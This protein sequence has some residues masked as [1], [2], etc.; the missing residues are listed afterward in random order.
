MIAIVDLDL[1]LDHWGNE[2]VLLGDCSRLLDL[3][4]RPFRLDGETG[5]Y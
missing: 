1:L 2:V 5:I 4:G 3:G